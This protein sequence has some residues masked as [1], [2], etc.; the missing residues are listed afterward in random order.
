MN[1]D[2]DERRERFNNR[3]KKRNALMKSL[4]YPIT[5]TGDELITIARAASLNRRMFDRGAEHEALDEAFQIIEKKCAAILNAAEVG[6][7]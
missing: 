3:A 1:E 4:S 2:P 6:D 7:G 5:L